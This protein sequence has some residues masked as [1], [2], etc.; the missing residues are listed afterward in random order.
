VVKAPAGAI[1]TC[2]IIVT[3][4]GGSSFIVPADHFTYN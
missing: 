2:D 3:T 1:G 4:P